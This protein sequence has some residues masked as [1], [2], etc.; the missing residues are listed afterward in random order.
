[1]PRRNF[2]WNRRSSGNREYRRYGF[3]ISIR[4]GEKLQARLNETPG[5]PKASLTER[6]GGNVISILLDATV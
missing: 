1:M 4:G 5:S 6:E 3:P 2:P